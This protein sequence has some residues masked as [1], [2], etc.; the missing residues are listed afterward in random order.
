MTD[1]LIVQMNVLENQIEELIRQYERKYPGWTVEI[2][3]IGT[4][5]A[6]LKE[7]QRLGIPKEER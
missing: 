2:D 3:S 4:W 6:V 7:D 1:E 5:G